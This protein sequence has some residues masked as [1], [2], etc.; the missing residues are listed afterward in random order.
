MAGPRQRQF[1]TRRRTGRR[2]GA[3]AA[4]ADRPQAVTGTMDVPQVVGP[5]DPP[6]GDQ[7]PL[8]ARVGGPVLRT[9]FMSEHAG[10]STDERMPLI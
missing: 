1:S 9:P 8:A 7:F 2:T 6:G 10:L 5:A 4:G 3:R